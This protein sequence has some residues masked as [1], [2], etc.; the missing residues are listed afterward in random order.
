MDDVGR[1]E[2]NRGSTE[3]RVRLPEVLRQLFD[4]IAEPFVPFHSL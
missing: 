2:M 4:R 1:V 3:A